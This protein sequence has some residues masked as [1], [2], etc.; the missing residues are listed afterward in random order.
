MNVEQVDII[1]WYIMRFVIA[2]AFGLIVGLFAF[3][4]LQPLI[5]ITNWG[6]VGF[7]ILSGALLFRKLK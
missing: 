1:V 3:H 6:F 4:L 2:A 5:N 7:W